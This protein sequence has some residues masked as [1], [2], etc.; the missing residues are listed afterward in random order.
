M[1]DAALHLNRFEQPEYEW[2]LLDRSR[3]LP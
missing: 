3:A 1:G 2:I